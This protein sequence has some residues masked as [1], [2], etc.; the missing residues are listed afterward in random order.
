MEESSPPYRPARIRVTEE[1]CQLLWTML[2]FYLSA[3]KEARY[4]MGPEDKHTM[5][6]NIRLT[7]KIMNEV[8]RTQDEMGWTTQ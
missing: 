3:Q 5:N 8:R 7:Q 1:T 2:G 6:R 4:N